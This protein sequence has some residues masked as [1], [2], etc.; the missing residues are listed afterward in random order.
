MQFFGAALGGK[1]QKVAK[2]VKKRAV[3]EIQNLDEASE[4]TNQGS[5]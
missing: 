1:G 5:P 4:G 2:K 3:D